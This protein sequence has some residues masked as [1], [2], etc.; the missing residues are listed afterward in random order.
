MTVS[1]IWMTTIIDEA[2]TMS[3]IA[4]KGTGDVEVEQHR[5]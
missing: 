1:T 5:I 4:A 3:V 2:S